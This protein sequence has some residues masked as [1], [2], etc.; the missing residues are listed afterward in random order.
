MK[1]FAGLI[2]ALC[3]ISST[4]Y[5]QQGKPGG[6][7]GWG[8]A[9]PEERATRLTEMMKE[10]LKLTAAQEPKVAAINLKYAKK[11]EEIRSIADTAQ[12]RKTFNATNKQRETEMKAVLTADQFKMYQKQMEELKARRGMGG[13]PKDG[14]R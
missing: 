14:K 2:L 9:T 5:A 10:N 11:N 4:M 3:L 1:L 13:G 6:G 8:K 7:G 12:Q